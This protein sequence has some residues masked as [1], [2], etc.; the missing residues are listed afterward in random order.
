MMPDEPNSMKETRSA[1]FTQSNPFSTEGLPSGKKYL[2]GV[3]I[4]TYQSW[5]PLKNAATD[6]QD[7]ARLLQERYDFE[8]GNMTLLLDQKATR[9]SIVNGLY[10]LTLSGKLNPEDSLLIYF[11]GHG[12]LDANENGYWA[13]WDSQPNDIS[14]LIPSSTIRDY[15]GSMKCRHVLL[16]SDS[17][18]SGALISRGGENGQDLVAI[19]LE[20]KISR[21]ILT[22][23]GKKQ[24]VLDGNGRN[25]PFAAAILSELRHNTMPRLITDELFGRIRNIVRAN[26]QQTPEYDPLYG[27]GDMSG[28]FVFRLKGYREEIP[29]TTENIYHGST[30]GAEVPPRPIVPPPPVQPPVSN[31]DHAAF[32][33]KLL[34]KISS[35]KT[36]E[37]INLLKEYAT[38]QNDSDMLSEV[39]L[40]NTKWSKYNRDQRLGLISFSDASIEFN[41]MNIGIIDLIQGVGK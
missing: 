12:Q 1:G 30:R 11:S 2:F 33:K 4:N 25:S 7:V 5:R 6:V 16:V 41:K 26:A 24:E 20:Q 39:T 31:F 35:G 40:I 23:G 21:R 38:G 15:I 8:E 32:R 3:G 27:A 19:E 14:S 28:R 22:S 10:N 34:D 37:V 9:N 36:E 17:C 29:A 18:F 13:P